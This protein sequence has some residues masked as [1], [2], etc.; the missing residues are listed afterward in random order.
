[1]SPAKCPSLRRMTTYDIGFGTNLYR[2]YQ[3]PRVDRQREAA[4]HEQNLSSCPIRATSRGG[5]GPDAYTPAGWQYDRAPS[6]R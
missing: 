5:C 3:K 6:S 2:A 4:A 1:M